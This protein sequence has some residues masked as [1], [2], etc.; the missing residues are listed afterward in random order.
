MYLCMHVRM[1]VCMY[2]IHVI[3]HMFCPFISQNPSS[4]DTDK[5]GVLP[6]SA[7]PRYDSVALLHQNWDLDST[8]GVEQ[9][10]KLGPGPK[11]GLGFRFY[12]R[13]ST[14]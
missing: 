8:A 6:S 7:E 3:Y 5:D 12:V 1:Y 2:T 10:S 13:V 9:E 4:F 11:Q 14:G